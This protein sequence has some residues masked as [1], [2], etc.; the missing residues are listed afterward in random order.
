MKNSLVASVM[1]FTF[2]IGLGVSGM[3]QP[4]KVIGF[5]NLFGSW[6]PS[7]M[8]VMLGAIA[9]HFVSYKLTQKRPKPLFVAKWHLPE[10]K[11]ITPA[12]IWGSLLFG[13][14][15]GLAGY[16]PGP[17]VTSLASF[18]VRP[19]LFVTSMLAGMYL[20]RLADKKLKLRK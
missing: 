3:T 20:F 2:A 6:D 17:A 12:L 4:Q 10:K 7:L 13:V 11:E 9:V 16:C 15:W 5:L 18:E 19:A 8:F 14:G 1:G